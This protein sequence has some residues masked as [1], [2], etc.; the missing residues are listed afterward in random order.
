MKQ[1]VFGVLLVLHGLAHAL[2]GIRAMDRVAGWLSPDM[3]VGLEVR[4]AD[5]INPA[6][7]ARAVGDT[8]FATPPRWL[9]LHKRFGWVVTRVEPNRVLVLRNW[10]AFVLLPVDSATTRLIVRTRAAGAERFAFVPLGWANLWV[11]EPAHFIMQRN[12]LLG[13]KRRAERSGPG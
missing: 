11:F 2:P 6:W 4:S 3:Q 1:R 12:M 13:I 10:G 8:V 5:R 7:Q 9:G